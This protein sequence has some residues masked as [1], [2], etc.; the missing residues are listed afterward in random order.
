MLMQTDAPVTLI[1]SLSDRDSFAFADAARISG[2]AGSTRVAP[3]IHKRAVVDPIRG[4]HWAMPF[5]KAVGISLGQ[6]QKE[7]KRLPVLHCCE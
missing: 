6:G 5:S 4:S 3:G 1:Q 7:G 2:L